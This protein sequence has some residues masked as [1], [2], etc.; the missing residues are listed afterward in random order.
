MEKSLLIGDVI[1]V[2]KVNYGPRVPMT[3]VA[4]PFSH[5]TLPTGGKAYWEGIKLDYHRLPGFEKI[6]RNDVVVFNYPMDADAPLSRPVD[7]RENYIKRCLAIAGDTLSI[8]NSQVYV[9]GK[10]DVRS[11]ER[12][13]GKERVSQVR[14]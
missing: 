2:S 6:E 5:H 4:F 7:K 14:S 12:S 13:V 3:P 9:N 10:A 1:I 11:E 8:V